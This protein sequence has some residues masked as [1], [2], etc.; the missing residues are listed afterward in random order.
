MNFIKLHIV[1][2]SNPTK[3]A[4]TENDL[5][6]RES[7]FHTCDIIEVTP[8][9]ADDESIMAKTYVR[10]SWNP[11][12]PISVMETAEEILKLIKEGEC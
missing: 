4:V 2:Q 1:Y 11:P 10:F 6:L 8:T 12:S 7:Y 9:I 5:L 3:K